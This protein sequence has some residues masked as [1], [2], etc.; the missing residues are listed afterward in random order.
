MKGAQKGTRAI[1][2][3]KSG[4]KAEPYYQK[5]I[6]E[7]FPREN[8]RWIEAWMR[9]ETPTLDAM[10]REKFVEEARLARACARAASPEENNCLASSLGL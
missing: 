3:T 2:A 6:A 8:A 5:L 9:V 7:I 1:Y 10:G 4:K